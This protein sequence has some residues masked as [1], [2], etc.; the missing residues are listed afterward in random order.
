MEKLFN[1]RKNR[2]YSEIIQNIHGL[3]QKATKK[4]DGHLASNLGAVESSI[5]LHD[6]FDSSRDKIIFDVSH[7]CY[8]HKIL[9]DRRDRGLTVRQTDG[10]VGFT[11][12]QERPHDVFFCGHAET[13]LSSELGIEVARDQLCQDYHVIA[14]L[15][16][17][18][19]TN[20]LTFEI[21]NN[22]EKARL[23]VML[24]DNDYAIAK[25]IGFIARYLKGIVHSNICNCIKVFFRHRLQKLR[26]GHPFIHLL[27][28]VKRTIKAFLLPSS[29]FECYGLPYIRP[30]DGYNVM[31][32]VDAL[33][34]CKQEKDPIIVY[35][36]T[37]KGYGDSDA[38]ICPRK[39]H[40]IALNSQFSDGHPEI[41]GGTLC[42]LAEKD[43]Q[44]VVMTADSIFFSQNCRSDFVI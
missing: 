36:K 17:A 15:G 1:Q 44:I 37:K 5:A 41:V 13:T 19:R 21:L 25:N 16:D 11:S 26:L 7:Q 2:K 31:D 43:L 27:S 32:L 8:A 40:G 38:E 14:V 4:N 34:F 28:C 20:A 30:T 18:S 33:N 10:I 12:P 24:N 22:I 29:L 3:I 23:I 9:T 39:S 42:D 35:V 6:A